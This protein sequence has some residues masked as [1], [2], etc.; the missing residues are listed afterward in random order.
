MIETR[1]TRLVA[2]V[3]G[4]RAARLGHPARVIATFERSLYAR[5]DE[6][7]LA[8]L[9]GEGLGRGPL[10]AIVGTGSFQA[11]QFRV[12]GTLAL[13]SAGAEIWR[14]AGF[15]PPASLSAGLAAL[16][17][18]LERV[19]PRGLAAA[20]STDAVAVRARDGLAALEAWIA[21]RDEQPIPAAVPGLLGLGPGLTPAGDD[22]VGG[23][24][25]ALRCFGAADEAERL[26]AQ[27]V[28]AARLAT[29]VISFAHLDAAASGEGAAALHDALAAIAVAD[30]PDIAA[31]LERL[32]RI[33]HSSG[34][35]ALAG[36]IAALR[37]LARR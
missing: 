36:A 30:I 18:A 16:T 14:P 15:A 7:R 23:A 9:G 3:V 22:A 25:I 28:P 12:G 29:S 20:G 26:A 1:A 19:P 34:W 4:S 13:D 35:D 5:D 27:T 37:G 10:N 17:R 11:T 31:S 8:C 24:M 6:G 33:G 21:A 32:D 2:R